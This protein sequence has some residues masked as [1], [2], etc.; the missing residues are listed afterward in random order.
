MYMTKTKRSMIIVLPLVT[1]YE[2]LRFII[3]NLRYGHKLKELILSDLAIR[4]SEL[5]LLYRL[6]R[7]LKNLKTLDLSNNLIT[8]TSSA[9]ICEI[10]CTNNLSSLYLSNNKFS[11]TSRLGL[12]NF[13]VEISTTRSNKSNIFLA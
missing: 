4:D 13:Y 5:E 10:I 1:Y 3:E 8:N 2:N 7:P 9:K 11:E 12:H 6:I